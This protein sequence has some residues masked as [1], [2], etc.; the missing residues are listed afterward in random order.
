MRFHILLT[1]ALFWSCLGCRPTCPTT[2]SWQR[3]VLSWK[4]SLHHLHACSQ[5]FVGQVFGFEEHLSPPTPQHAGAQSGLGMEM[6]MGWDG[7]EKPVLS[8]GIPMESCLWQGP[9]LCVHSLLQHW[10]A[11]CPKHTFPL[12]PLLSQCPLC[13]CLAPCVRVPGST[14]A[15]RTSQVLVSG[16]QWCW[17]SSTSVPRADG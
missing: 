8:C 7:R 9:S 16:E 11:H 5:A 14:W 6:G 1:A 15:A 3:L 4:P 10:Q 12:L 2:L 17:G 13:L